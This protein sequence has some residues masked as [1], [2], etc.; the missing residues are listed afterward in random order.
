ML[1]DSH[2][3][4]DVLGIGFGPSNLALAIALSEHPHRLSAQFVD[5]QSRFG[6]HRGMLIPGARMQVS[7]LKDLVTLRNPK[8]HY[9]FV[10][11]LTERGRLPDFI[12][13]QSFFPTRQEFHDYLDWAQEALE[14]DVSYS[15]RMTGIEATSDG[16]EVR[17]QDTMGSRPDR[18]MRARALV[19]GCGTFPAMPSGINPTA[20]QWHSSQL[21]HRL[22]ALDVPP[23][24][25]AV[26]GAGQ[27]A[28]EAVAYLH[29]QY[30]GAQV[31]AIFARYGYSPADDSPYANRIFDPAAVDDFYGA[32]AEVRRQL[33]DYHRDTNYAAVDSPLIADLYDR[34]YRE[35]V[36]GERR[37]WM[38]N[39]SRIAAVDETP[40]RVRLAITHLP[41]SSTELLDCD[42][43]V[44]ATGYRPLDVR[45]FLGA[46]ASCYEFDEEGRPVVERDYRLRPRADAPGEI[47]LNGSVEH[48]HGLSSSLLSNVAVRAG[49]IVDSLVAE[50]ETREAVASFKTG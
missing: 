45:A 22:E 20:R 14:P 34:E 9:T 50:A 37:L 46:L 19:L 2:A 24:R 39:A 6:W 49:E 31:H 23:A 43:V 30:P 36:S 44:Y 26:V 40:D 12:N 48:S 1:S 16:F 35:R 41:T 17:L 47:Y 15:S 27:S 32:P 13:Q 29:S 10:N 11:Y 5:A 38:H 21:L 3:S 28:A 7:F 18:L 25:V 33:V 4:H 8:S 42:A